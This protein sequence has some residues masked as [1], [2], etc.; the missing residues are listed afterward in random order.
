M[1][2]ICFF[3]IL[4]VAETHPT[5]ELWSPSGQASPYLHLPLGLAVHVVKQSLV[6]VEL[7][8]PLF[9][10]I[11]AEVIAQW[12]EHDV[13]AVQGCLLTVLLQ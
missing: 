11:I 2:V 13:I 8:V 6:V 1:E 4:C 3:H 9:H 5:V 10:L 12:H 7:I